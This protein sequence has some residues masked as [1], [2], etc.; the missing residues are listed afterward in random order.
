MEHSIVIMMCFKQLTHGIQC[1]FDFLQDNLCVCGI[2]S[3]YNT[4]ILG[5]MLGYMYDLEG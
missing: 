5:L 1:T 3:S 2:G 4:H